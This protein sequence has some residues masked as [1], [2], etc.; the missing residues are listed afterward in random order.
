MLEIVMDGLRQSNDHE[1]FEANL[2][3]MRRIVNDD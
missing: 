2:K 1:E 3:M